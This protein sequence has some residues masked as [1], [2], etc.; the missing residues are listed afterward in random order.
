MSY[1]G[2]SM[3]IASYASQ[4]FLESTVIF[5]P[6]DIIWA[7]GFGGMTS[8]VVFTVA[9]FIAFTVIIYVLTTIA[10]LFHRHK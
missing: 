8:L 4:S 6:G 1:I 3:L 2:I 5:L 7:S 9:A 10:C